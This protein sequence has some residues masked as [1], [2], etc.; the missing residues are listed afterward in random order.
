MVKNEETIY[1]R[2]EKKGIRL[3]PQRKDII[4]ILIENNH[5]HLSASDIYDS[6]KEENKIMGLA[7]VYRTLDLLTKMGMVMKRDFDSE[8][9]HY[10][11]VIDQVNHHHLICKNCGKVIEIPDILPK[12]IKNKLLEEKG[13]KCMTCSIKF[14]GYCKE[15]REKMAKKNQI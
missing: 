2:I 10:E 14:Y 1:E 3:T 5:K 6:L 4:R 8:L 13:F 12:D 7:T 11:L 9:S 15:C